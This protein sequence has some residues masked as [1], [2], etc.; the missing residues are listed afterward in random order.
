MSQQDLAAASGVAQPNISA[1][2]HGRRRPSAETLQRLVEGCGF[3]LVV[4]AGGQAIV[5]PSPDD[6]AGAEPPEPPTITPD[7]PMAKRVRAL[8]AALD[9]SEAIVRAR[10]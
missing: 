5:L 2:E 1:I 7:T 6:E 10:R 9:A 4:R 3:N 8:V